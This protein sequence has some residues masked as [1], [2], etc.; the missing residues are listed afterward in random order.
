MCC[1]TQT[2]PPP[3]GCEV[4]GGEGCGGTAPRPHHPGDPAR[5]PSTAT[6]GLQLA[7]P[8]RRGSRGRGNW[9]SKARRS[10]AG[11]ETMAEGTA[12]MASSTRPSPVLR[13]SAEGW[14]TETSARSPSAAHV[15]QRGGGSP[16]ATASSTAMH[17]TW[18]CVATSPGLVLSLRHQIPA[19][20]PRG[21]PPS[22]ACPHQPAIRPPGPG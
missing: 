12:S 8:E 7:A 16:V 22:L 13:G 14:E 18:L 3:D 15:K 17:G 1:E 4:G 10:L 2:R 9:P 21:T 6:S 11:E 20:S 5:A 19:L